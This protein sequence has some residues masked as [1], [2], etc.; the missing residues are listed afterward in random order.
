MSEKNTS[1]F[2]T[3]YVDHVLRQL[4]EEDRKKYQKIGKYMYGTESYPDNRKMSDMKS[5]TED[6]IL[7]IKAAIRSGLHPKDLTR[8]ELQY[9][10]Q[11]VG[12]EWV[13]EFGYS[14]EECS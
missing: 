11:N 12:T 3:E 6:S 4:S 2:N 10:N 14:V 13:E 5:S 8:N 9:M 7:Y 1:F